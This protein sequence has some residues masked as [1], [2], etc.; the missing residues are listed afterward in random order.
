MKMAESVFA[1]VQRLLS[2]KVEDTVDRMETAG[3]EGVM[4]EAIREVDRAIDELRR[5]HDGAMA[6][7]LQ[8]VRQQDMVNKKVA[9]LGEK[10]A[11]AV[12]QGRD[13]LAEAALSR[14]VEFEGETAKL[15]AVQEASRE[16]EQ[17]L[18]DA[19]TALKTRKTQMQEVLDAYCQSKADAAV[20][21]DGA[22]QL[23]QAIDKKVENAEAAFD[24]AMGGA[25]GVNFS[26]TDADTINKVAE[27]DGLQ[28]SST[29]ASR[30]AALKAGKAA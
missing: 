17:K 3:G 1:R 20:G 15:E 11:F 12:E 19:I 25:G 29:V 28:K 18:D 27:L 22:R 6:R 23:A 2:A 14:Q 24:R 5:D 10:A 4:R 21:G 13:D 30:L 26:R 9:E 7:R 16:Q 8:A